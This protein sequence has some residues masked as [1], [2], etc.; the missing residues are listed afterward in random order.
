MA[1]IYRRLLD[2]IERAPRARAAR[3]GC[4]CPA[5]RSPGS[6]SE[7]RWPH[8]RARVRSRSWAAGWR[9]SPPRSNA[10]TRARAVTLLRG[11]ARASAARRSPS[12][13]TGLW[14]DNGQ[15]VFLRCCTEYR[16]L[17]DR[18]GVESQVTPPGP[19]VDP[20]A[21]ARRAAGARC[22]GAGLPAPLHLAGAILALP[23][24]H[25]ARAAPGRP[26]PRSRSASS[27]S[28]TRRSTSRRSARGS[29]AHGQS[30]NAVAALWDLIALPT[31]QPPRGGGLAGARREG[32][33]D[34]PARRRRRGGHRLRGRSAPAAPRRLGRARARAGR[35]RRSPAGARVGARLAEVDAD[36]GRARGP[37]RR[38][39]EPPARR[40]GR[41]GSAPPG[42]VADREP[43]R[44]LRPA[45]D[46]APVRG[47]LR[48][49]R[50]SS[51]STGRPRPA[52]SAASASPS[53]SRARSATRSA[54]SRSC[55]RS[56][57][58]RSR[59]CSRPRGQR[60]WS[61]SSSPASRRRPSAACPGPDACAPGRARG[62]P[63]LYLAG[64][65]TDTGWPATM[66]GAVRSGRAAAREALAF[67]AETWDRS[68]RSRQEVA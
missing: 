17:L 27:T 39:R 11:P 19:A 50:C 42:R 18:L 57:S 2:R 38:R 35:R 22:G 60:P 41:G 48:H 5:G 6:P 51:S 23:L 56:S 63:G 29:A 1:G 8:D 12:S 30:P 45:G 36:G 37:A 49:A 4:R 40:R 54:P 31:R 13:A 52:S 44:R 53:R 67:A 14:L 65:W 33:Q 15:H 28:T 58:R 68:S 16:G 32:V 64:A 25:P 9:A 24:P 34:R 10:P 26:V 46:G 59:V 47:R 61:G 43:P 20:G 7:P 55:A 62:A 66:E 3:S 21:R